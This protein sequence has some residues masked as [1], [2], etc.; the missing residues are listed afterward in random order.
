MGPAIKIGL[1]AMAAAPDAVIARNV[2][3]MSKA[4]S[5]ISPS[6]VENYGKIIKE[7]S[8][9]AKRLKDATKRYQIGR[10]ELSAAKKQLSTLR[11][12]VKRGHIPTAE[13]DLRATDALR[14]AQSLLEQ[15]AAQVRATSRKLIREKPTKKAPSRVVR[16]ATS[17]TTRRATTSS[18]ARRATTSRSGAT[19]AGAARR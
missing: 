16:R 19:R 2:T 3:K 10:K 15:Q 14:M 12:Q 1:E 7:K 11:E 4:M 5:R 9:L 13:I 17:G 6:K 8:A 18:G